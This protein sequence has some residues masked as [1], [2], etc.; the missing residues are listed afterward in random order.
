MIELNNVDKYFNRHKKNELHVINH[1]SFKIEDKGL[2]ALLGH[3]GSGKTTLLNSIGGLDKIKSGK[4]IING[5]KISS[6]NSYTV[7]KIRNL[8]IGYIFQD[9]KLIDDM[10]VYDN[11]AIPL[12]MIGLKDKK[13]IKKRVEYVLDKVGMLRYK[14]RPASMLS[15]GERQRV[16]I[17]RAIVKNP[18]IIL[19][20]EPTGNLDSKNSLEIMKIIKAISKD[21]LVILVTHET[22]LAKFYADRII[23]LKDGKIE[24]DYKNNLEEELDYTIDNNF[25]LK[26][27]KNKK[28]LENIDIYSD[29]KTSLPLTI[30][31]KGDTIYI[32]SNKKIE[33][34]DENSSIKFVNDNYKKINKKEILDYSFDFND[35]INDNFK[36]K[37]SSIFNPISLIKNGF[38]KVF[39]FSILKKILLIGFLLSGMFIT[40]SICSIIPAITIKDEDFVNKNSNYYIAI[41]KKIKIDDYLEYEKIDDINYLIPGDSMISLPIKYKEYYQ[42]SKLE[43]SLTGSMSSINMIS[44]DDIVFGKMPTNDNEIVVDKKAILNMFNETDYAKMAGILTVQDLIDREIQI[45]NMDTLKIVGITDLKSP[46]IYLSESLF[47]NIISNTDTEISS[48]IV[49]YKLYENKIELKQGVMPINDYEVIV[50]INNKDDMPINKE[51]DQ[52]VNN[53]KLKV[54]GY[55]FSSDNINYSLVN[56]NTIKYN[57]INKK[58]DFII[59]SKNIENALKIFREKNVNILSSYEQSK[60]EYLKEKKQS[61]KSTLIFSGTVLL[62]SFIEIFLMIRSSFLSRIKEIGILRAIGVKKS[63]IYKMFIS[64]IFAITTLTC[65]PGVII[66]S[67][68]I[69][70]LTQVK[71]LNKMFYIDYKVSILAIILILIF[72]LIIGLLPVYN[73]MR[74]R[75]AEILSRTDLE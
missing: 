49:D 18:N 67:Y 46:S 70:Q 38:E 15:G 21:R 28:S 45:N 55:Y 35:K 41:S 43:D 12:T 4:I 32:E 17:A 63:D 53:H 73:L 50:N 57:V 24:K 65:I 47:I 60:K 72:N 27:F 75:P 16:G 3:S 54:V 68:I 5:K 48:S 42:T 36:K 69:N 2:V 7:D 74:K 66:M 33:V 1:T 10:S 61:I 37:Y 52:K 56:N 22:Q 6:K 13:E 31:V 19:A 39:S 11:V 25:Y 58:S 30:V 9:Y 14:K 26:D 40:Y 34:V 44:N 64:E 29:D 20:D 8:N 51:I 71:Y 62:I 59:Y 23:E